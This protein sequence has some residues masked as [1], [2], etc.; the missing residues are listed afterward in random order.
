M[1]R[2]RIRMRASSR[3]GGGHPRTADRR[4]TVL[5]GE[6]SMPGRGQWEAFVKL[7][8]ILACLGLCVA[9]LGGCSHAGGCAD[10]FRGGCVP[11]P[12]EAVTES[13]AAESP[14]AESSAA[15]SPAAAKPAAVSPGVAPV[16]PAPVVVSR[17]DPGAFA[18]ADD[19]QCRSY[20]LTFGSRD[21]A[22]C[23]IRLSAQHRGLDPNLGTGGAASR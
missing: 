12:E 2:W 17:G 5:A 22:D 4:G 10:T 16:S 7:S 3:Y 14:A 18:E 1:S 20:G 8:V 15:I 9:A 19:K 13:P 11:L 23:R 6:L 21:Y